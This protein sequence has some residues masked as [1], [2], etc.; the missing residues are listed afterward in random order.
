[1][2]HAGGGFATRVAAWGV[3]SIVCLC[4]VSVMLGNIARA[5]ATGKLVLNDAYTMTVGRSVTFLSVLIVLLNA[6]PYAKRL[7]VLTVGSSQQIM[8]FAHGVVP[9]LK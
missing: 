2:D 4:A 1:M 5:V 7:C 8:V 6:A 3:I 9:K